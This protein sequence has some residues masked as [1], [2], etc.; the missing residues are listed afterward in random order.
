MLF[1]RLKSAVYLG[2]VGF[3]EIGFCVVW[4][5]KEGQM[6]ALREKA[7]LVTCVDIIGGVCNQDDSVTFI[8]QFAQEEHHFAIQTRIEA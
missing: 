7:D 8:C 1:C 4:R 2:K 3:L 5:A 6:P